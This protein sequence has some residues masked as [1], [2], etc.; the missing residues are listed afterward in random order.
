MVDKSFLLHELSAVSSLRQ[1]AAMNR[2]TAIERAFELADEGRNIREIRRILSREGYDI[3]QVYGRVIVR[4][5]QVR[6]AAFTKAP[7][8]GDD[9]TG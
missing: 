6:A 5:L 3:G 2:K 7:L 1:G 8:A 4:Q 9:L